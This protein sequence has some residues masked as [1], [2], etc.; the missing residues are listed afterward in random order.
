[1]T[2]Q[3]LKPFT[4][5]ES[6]EKVLSYIKSDDLHTRILGLYA[7]AKG[8]VFENNIQLSRFYSRHIREAREL[9]CYSTEKIIRV[10]KYLIDNADYK[11]GLST[12]IKHIDE[13]MDKLDGRE[14]I[15]ILS[16]GERI[17]SVER[18]KELERSGRIYYTTKGWKENFSG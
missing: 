1:M 7:K 18:I 10:M 14:P 12:V 16:D 2:K 4:K 8:V 5:E 11:W 3:K 15:I 9:D 17:Y 13:D 6:A